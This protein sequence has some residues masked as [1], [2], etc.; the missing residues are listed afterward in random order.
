MFREL[1]IILILCSS[2]NIFGQDSKPPNIIMMIGDGMGLSA[3]SSG[4][5]SNNNYTSLE[6]SEYI[7]LLKT[8]SLDD[9]V[10]D[11]AASGTA[12][13]SG[14]KTYNRTV[15]LDGNL[16]SVK[17]ILEICRDRGYTTAIVATSTI[18]HATPASYYSKVKSRYQYDEIAS[19]LS[20]SNINFFV[21]GGEKYF[22]DRVDGRN[23]INEMDDYFFANSLESFKNI[24]SNKIGYLTYYDEP[25]GKHEGREPSLEDIAQITIQKLKSFDNPFFLLVEGSQ[26]DWGGHDNDSEHLISEML[27]FDKTIETVFNFAD[28]DKNT[29][30][31]I[32]ADHETGGAAIVDG[33]LEESFVKIKYVS[34]DHTATMVP[35][36]SLG[37]YSSLFKGVYDNTEI[38]DKLEAIIK[39]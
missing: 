36:F 17:S 19:Q 13:S 20:K 8:H 16:S 14:V 21:G 1:T 39:K 3:I 23:L 35:I 18:V 32:T 24:N 5:Y 28:K 12:M 6:R 2:I 37:P 31:V 29:L 27:E 34:G 25:V 26:I 9:L 15:G 38:F 4:M 7:G 10:T 22:N 11:S 30:V 33:N